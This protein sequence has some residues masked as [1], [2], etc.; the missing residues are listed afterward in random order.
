MDKKTYLLLY[1]IDFILAEY[2][3]VLHSDIIKNNSY[4]GTTIII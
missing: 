1:N 2:I 3:I 4:I